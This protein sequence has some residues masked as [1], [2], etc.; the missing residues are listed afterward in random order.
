M[1]FVLGLIISMMLIVCIVLEML[2]AVRPIFSVL[3][4]G[5]VFA[6]AVAVFFT[7]MLLTPLFIF[8]FI[9]NIPILI[10]AAMAGGGKD[11]R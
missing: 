7:G 8:G 11:G 4:L 9:V 3:L 6:L 1:S 2:T 10:I 5:G